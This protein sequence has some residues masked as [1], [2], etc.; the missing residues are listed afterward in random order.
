MLL[1]YPLSETLIALRF[2]LT[3]LPDAG[4]PTPVISTVFT[5]W[6]HNYLCIQ[7]SSDLP[8]TTHWT[9]FSLLT[10]RSILAFVASFFRMLV[11][12]SFVWLFF[13][14]FRR[15]GREIPLTLP[16]NNGLALCQHVRPRPYVMSPS[17]GRFLGYT[18]RRLQDRVP[19]MVKDHPYFSIFEV[20]PI[21]LNIYPRPVTGLV[22]L[23]SRSLSELASLRDTFSE[24]SKL[25]RV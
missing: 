19:P 10:C 15:H 21:L 16:D 24:S 9:S 14:W 3:Y 18:V 25:F 12:V 13:I 17:L 20:N 5:R 4:T 22:V 7:L 1:C 2:S 8:Q 23:Y 11:V 6:N